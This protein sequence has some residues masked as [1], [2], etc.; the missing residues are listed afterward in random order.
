M[1]RSSISI[2]AI[3]G[4]IGLLAVLGVLQYRWLSQV[5]EAELEKQ[6]KRLDSD[7]EHFAAD[8]NREIQGA[9]F[10]FQVGADTWKKNNW[11][12]FNKRYDFWRSKTAYPALIK[13]IVFVANRPDAQPLIY[14][15]DTRAF[16]PGE[17]PAEFADLRKRFTA[18]GM[19]QP[20]YD[21]VPALVMPIHDEV[22]PIRHIFIREHA[23]GGPPA[24]EIPA[25]FGYLT[26][27]L[28]T[29]T[30]KNQVL[31]ELNRKYFPEGDF[32]VSVADRSETPLFHTLNGTTGSDA[33]ARLFDVSPDKFMFYTS[34]NMTPREDGE[35][36]NDV[37]VTRRVE[38]ETLTSDIRGDGKGGIMK[39]EVNRGEGPKA[40]VLER[41]NPDAA[42]YWTLR[43]QHVDGSLA[44][45]V[46]GIKRQSLAVS[47]GL[48]ALLGTGILLIFVSAQRA[49]TLAQRQI[50]FVSSVS[51]EFR[52][53]L[54]VIYSAGQNLADGVAKEEGQ[55]A[56]YGAMIRGEGK[57]LSGMVEQI[58]EFAGANSGRRKYNLREA[59]VAAVVREALDECMPLLTERQF[60]V[61]TNI[62]SDLP[63]VVADRDALSG[64]VQNLLQ[65]SAKYSNGNKWLRVSAEN[66]G[67]R[68]HISVEDRGI[69][70]S[71]SDMRQIFQPFF[72]SKTVVDSQIH[73]SGLGLSLVKQF[74]DAHGGKV[75]AESEVGK[76]SKFTIDLAAA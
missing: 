38:S 71:R 6:Q 65:N 8:F 66:A 63:P 67:G 69:G 54:A 53:P 28:D 70:I 49:R 25:K 26:V 76:G 31:P 51:H 10:N 19:F 29:D 13:S 16:Q 72:R 12:E 30:L 22:E 17:V 5:S 37:F 23:P 4:F 55:V 50:D 56:R 20:V 1:K 47:Y 58:L 57:K 39:I 11:S 59:D 40:T 45:Y 9:Y 68:V 61:E 60:E 48:L 73:G 27:I 41:T 3:C 2:L 75:Y 21:D 46:S 36:R 74:A 64:A 44:N 52:T 35:R 33:T 62:S 14:N 32:A 34:T 24:A 42:G 7:T 43:V 15:P 18:D